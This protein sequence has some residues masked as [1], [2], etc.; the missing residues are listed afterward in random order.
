MND[1]VLADEIINIAEDD[2]TIGPDSKLVKRYVEDA[3]T[4]FFKPLTRQWANPPI[5]FFNLKS[6][7]DQETAMLSSV[8]EIAM[9]SSYQ[10]IIGMGPSVIPLILNEM[11]IKPGHWFWALKSVTGEDPVQSKYRG[12]IKEMT[13][14][15]IQWGKEQNYLP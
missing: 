9:H 14:A 10:Q 8:T 12:R 13:K 3:A 5:R 6:Q 1:P 2:S 15:W 11:T 4:H 7:W